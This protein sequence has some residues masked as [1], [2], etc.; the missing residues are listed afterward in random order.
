MQ[1][2]RG[3]PFRFAIITTSAGVSVMLGTCSG[4][5]WAISQFWQHLHSRLQPAV[6]SDSAVA[7]GSTWKRGF[8]STGSI[9][10]EHGR[11]W[12]RV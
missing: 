12:T 7:P 6:A 9:A 4:R 5:A 8:F 10:S 2:T 3:A 1:A 11:E